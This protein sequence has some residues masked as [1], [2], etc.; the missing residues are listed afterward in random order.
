MWLGGVHISVAVRRHMISGHRDLTHAVVEG[1]CLRA[2]MVCTLAKLLFNG[3]AVEK[4]VQTAGFPA[5]NDKTSCVDCS[6]FGPV[7][8]P[9]RMNSGE[10]D[11]VDTV[12]EGRA[13][14]PRHGYAGITLWAE[15][16]GRQLNKV[17][18]FGVVGWCAYFG[19]PAPAYELGWTRQDEY[20]S[21]GAMLP[22]P[23]HGYAGIALW[24]EQH[25]RQLI[26]VFSFGVVEWC[27]YFGC[28]A[29]AYELWSP[30]PSPCCSGG[31][32]LACPY[33]VCPGKTL[34]YRWCRGEK[35]ANSAF[36][37]W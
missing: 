31:L 10:P 27:S 24:A 18:L 13:T 30:W 8:E 33:G 20:C 11:P 21:P 4:S 36:P 32:L 1:Y 15:Q 5:G 2:H 29:P 37:G 9:V 35:P 28:P 19:C 25:C 16:H 3:D 22:A 23:G 7:P 17:C 6:T 12:A 34:V 26:N 14:H